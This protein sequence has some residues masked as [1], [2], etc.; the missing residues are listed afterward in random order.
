MVDLTCHRFL[1]S[2]FI[3][4]SVNT[5]RCDPSLWTE[6]R[7]RKSP[8]NLVIS[9]TRCDS[10]SANFEEHVKVRM[11]KPDPLFSTHWSLKISMAIPHQEGLPGQ[12]NVVPQSTATEPG[13]HL[14][15]YVFAR[16]THFRLTW[17]I[18]QRS[19]VG[20]EKSARAQLLR[21]R[22]GVHRWRSR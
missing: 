17:Q 4:C 9:T 8:G 20:R 5:K 16:S 12:S 6:D 3:R 13:Q 21:T 2:R 22:K 19:R 15:G 7:R 11:T 18:G 10:W 1:L 14:H